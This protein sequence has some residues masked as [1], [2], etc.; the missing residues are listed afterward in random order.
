MPTVSS[1]SLRAFRAGFVFTFLFSVYGLSYSGTFSSDDEHIFAASAQNLARQGSLSIP[2]VYGNSRLQELSKMPFYTA[3]EPGQAITGAIFVR[4]ADRLGVG[5][6][7]ALFWL[8]PLVTAL[9]G[10]V[11]FLTVLTLGYSERAAVL[12]A[13]LYGT[14]TIAWPYAR[15]HYRDPLAA[16]LVAAAYL[17]FEWGHGERR[18]PRDR[19]LS[20]ALISVFI[21][22]AVLTKSMAA[23][24][25]PLLWAI[26]LWRAR[27]ENTSVSVVVGAMLLTLLGAILATWLMAPEGSYGRFSWPYIGFLANA[28]WIKTRFAV[29]QSLVGPL[30]S[31]G[32]G[33]FVYSPVLLLA[34]TSWFGLR[35]DSRNATVFPLLLS[36]ALVAL[37]SVFL[38]RDWWTVT[39]WG[40]RFTLLATPPL[41]VACVPALER[42]IFSRRKW[43]RLSLFL[44]ITISM[45][46]QVGGVAVPNSAYVNSLVSPQAAQN[47]AV[48]NPVRSEIVAHWQLLFSGTRSEFALARLG[49]QQAAGFTLLFGWLILLTL[50]ISGLRALRSWGRGPTRHGALLAAALTLAIALPIT[51]LFALTRDPAYSGQR[52]AYLEAMAFLRAEIAPDDGLL[53]QAYGQPLWKHSINYSQGLPE[54]YGLAWYF[55]SA[56]EVERMRASGDPGD[57]FDPTTLELLGN[58]ST[59]YE[60]VWL[61]NT[62]DHLPGRFELEHQWLERH[63]AREGRWLFEDSGQVAVSAFRLSSE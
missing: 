46:V 38:D 2:Q 59:K 60:R 44:L 1:L 23:A 57:G 39:N 8:N 30:F 62:L 51:E 45:L 58:L 35:K 37:Y 50:S 52:P 16:L 40:S 42:G 3:V 24:A 10:C 47:M 63:Y 25:L 5:T 19:A 18:T 22:A 61:V 28:A 33:L 36:L 13:V 54:W 29:M 55:P 41:V 56:D 15:T 53:V 26:G 32:K 34:L 49:E 21:A 11:V 20:W 17:V 9:T 7:H 12:A 43:L 31:P 48:W 4:L 27:R 6:V 14:A